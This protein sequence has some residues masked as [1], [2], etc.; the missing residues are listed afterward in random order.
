MDLKTKINTI[1]SKAEKLQQVEDYIAAY[2]EWDNV[3][4]ELNIT[5][6]TTKF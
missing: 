4:T 6:K 3:V 2:E 1:I 5:I